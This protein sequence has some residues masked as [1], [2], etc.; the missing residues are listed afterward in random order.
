M[1]VHACACKPTFITSNAAEELRPVV[2]CGQHACTHIHTYIH[3]CTHI[4]TTTIQ[5][6]RVLA[7]EIPVVCT[8]HQ[9]NA[10]LSLCLS[11]FLF[12]FLSLTYTRSFPPSLRSSVSHSLFRS[13]SLPL[14]RLL[15]SLLK[16]SCSCSIGCCYFKPAGRWSTLDPCCTSHRYMCMHV[17][18]SPLPLSV[19]LSVCACTCR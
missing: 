2:G 17:S 1:C 4:K 18:L 9:V 19:S 13:L 3:T 11:P 6:V 15:L 14:L 8:I 10:C 16:R 12:L 5:A 7:N